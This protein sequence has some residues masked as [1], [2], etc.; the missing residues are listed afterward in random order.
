MAAHY[1]F[2]EIYQ[3][4]TF[5]T[6]KIYIKSGTTPIDLTGAEVTFNLTTTYGK[7]IKEVPFIISD[8]VAGEITLNSWDVDLRSFDYC[9]ILKIKRNN[10][11]TLTYLVGEFPIL[12]TPCSC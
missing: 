6:R 4:N 10:G 1:N 7:C 2:P 8:P 9:Y 3:G 11:N 12:K 5:R